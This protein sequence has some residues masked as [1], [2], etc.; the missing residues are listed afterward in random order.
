VTFHWRGA[1]DGRP[2]EG[3]VD[4]G[5]ILGPPVVTIWVEALVDGKAHVGEGPWSGRATL[6][7]EVLARATIA[8]VL[9]TGSASFDPPAPVDDVPVDAVA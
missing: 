5:M 9:D 3:E 4:E 7:D 6:D 8:A 1:L 2:V